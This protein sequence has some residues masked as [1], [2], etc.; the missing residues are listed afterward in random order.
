MRFLVLSVGLL[1]LSMPSLVQAAPGPELTARLEK[2]SQ[3]PA[4]LKIAYGAE[5]SQFGE[6]SLP[7][8]K[9]PFPVIV[10]MHGGCWSSEFGIGHGRTFVNALVKE[11][12]A[13][14]SLE[15]RRVGEAG[16]GWPGTFLD[17]AA[18]TDRLRDLSKRYHLDLRRVIVGGHSAGG[19]LALW[20]A[21]RDKIDRGSAIWTPNPLMPQ[22]V[23]ALAPASGLTELIS[24]KSACTPLIEG[25]MGGSPEQVPD[26]Y[27]AGEP[28]RL[29]PIGIPQAIVVG[30]LDEDWA[31]VGQTYVRK[32]ESA[33]DKNVELFEAPRS[34]HFELITPQPPAWPQV[35]AALQYLK[36]KMK[37]GQ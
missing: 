13:V 28:E 3:A 10:W 29:L 22:A 31:W 25:L 37:P 11:G 7:K 2:L 35:R 8:G 32:A 30:E 9:G 21:A 34:G 23:L 1:A 33:G 12:Y 17:V 15:Y 4:G 36:D 16:G 18:A 19:Q 14:W 26:R 5:K 20:L 27:Q 6:L 24:R